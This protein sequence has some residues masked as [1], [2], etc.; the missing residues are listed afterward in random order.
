MTHSSPS[1]YIGADFE[2]DAPRP[3]RLSA[4]D[5]LGAVGEVLA[6]ERKAR[7]ALEAE[8]KKERKARTALAAELRDLR[9]KIET[10]ERGTKP[11]AQRLVP[12]SS[13]SM[14]A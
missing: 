14:I 11:A 12:A 6:G 1:D 3:P 9:A 2:F 8:L 13:N 10:I 4:Y 5:V 7:L